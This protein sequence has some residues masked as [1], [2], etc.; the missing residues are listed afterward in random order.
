MAERVAGE[1]GVRKVKKM[2]VGWAAAGLFLVSGGTA[3]AAT[4]GTPITDLHSGG[5]DFTD[6]AYLFNRPF[7][8]HGAFEWQGRLMDT[9]PRDGHNVYMQ[10]RI[11][12][13][14]WVR[15]NGKQK[16]AVWLH[17]SNWDGAQLY[18]QKAELRA[19][20]DRGSLRPD[21]CS[22]TM[23]FLNPRKG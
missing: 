6:G 19:C 12:S 17:R 4:W 9:L 2:L 20:R 1:D 7:N 11:E 5:V 22:P 13:H 23:R 14:D 16:K 8:N 10:V 18:T 15:Y 21:N 3:F